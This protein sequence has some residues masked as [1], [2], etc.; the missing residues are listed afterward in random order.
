[1]CVKNIK[2]LCYTMVRGIINKARMLI[3]WKIGDIEDLTYE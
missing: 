1:M 3:T 2:G